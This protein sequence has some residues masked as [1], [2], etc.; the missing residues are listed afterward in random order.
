MTSEKTAIKRKAELETLR[1]REIL[2]KCENLKI[3]PV[4]EKQYNFE[5]DAVR[6]DEK[7]KILVFFGKRGVKIV[8]QGNSESPLYKKINELTTGESS[9][10]DESV[11]GL[12]AK[13]IG[14]DESG[15][16]DFFGPLAVAAFYT[17]EETTEKLLKL[18]VRDSKTLSEQQ[19]VAI[20]TSIK[21]KFRENFSVYVLEPQ[22]YNEEYFKHGQN[23]N[24]LLVNAHSAAVKPLLEKFDVKF[25]IT[26]KFSNRALT[27]EN[28]TNFSDVKFVQETKAEKYPAVAAASILARAEVVAWFERINAR[29]QAKLGITLPKGASAEVDKTAQ[30]LADT[31]SKEDLKRICKTHFKNF[32]KIR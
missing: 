25:V 6:N 11:I 3:S 22:K 16:G 2:A 26:D 7:V 32:S 27:L 10:F 31:Y 1:L 8:L 28:K 9:L 14:S 30:L 4:A 15:K 18:G 20:S 12:P 19:I 23:L 29:L 24:K 17:D 13:Y 21:K 5:F